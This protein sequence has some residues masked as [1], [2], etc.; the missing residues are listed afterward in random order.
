MEKSTKIRN[1]SRINSERRKAGPVKSGRLL[2]KNI[3]AIKFT[4]T[5]RKRAVEKTASHMDSG[6]YLVDMPLEIWTYVPSAG[7]DLLHAAIAPAWRGC[8]KA[9]IGV[10]RFQNHVRPGR[11]AAICSLYPISKE[12]Q[13][14][15]SNLDKSA[16]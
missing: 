3:H 10:P 14:I 1:K 7:R 4:G 9:Q 2:L 5:Q 13:S 11:A 15:D 8:P 6:Y 16:R 12:N